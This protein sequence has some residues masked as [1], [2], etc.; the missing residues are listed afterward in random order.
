[1]AGTAAELAGGWTAGWKRVWQGGQAPVSCR[2]RVCRAVLRSAADL[3]RSQAAWAQQAAETKMVCHWHQHLL[4]RLAAQI[5][6]STDKEPR[7]HQW[8]GRAAHCRCRCRPAT[9]AGMAPWS[10]TPHNAVC[11]TCSPFLIS[12]P[13]H[14]P[15]RSPHRQVAEREAQVGALRPPILLLQASR[16]PQVLKQ[17]TGRPRLE[18]CRR[19]RQ[20]PPLACIPAVECS[21]GAQ[22][23]EQLQRWWPQKLSKLPWRP[24]TIRAAGGSGGRLRRPAVWCVPSL[25][26]LLAADGFTAA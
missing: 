22:G 13:A 10:A 18:L 25:H 6:A 4:L 21:H 14:S 3:Q 5:T 7:R 9:P 24:H 23:H 8:V 12:G 15:E 1:M 11:R 20:L 26:S 19:R 17:W 16:Q 2:L